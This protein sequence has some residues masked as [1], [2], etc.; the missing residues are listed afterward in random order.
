MQVAEGVNLD[1][2]A[3]IQWYML[4]ASERTFIQERLAALVGQSPESWPAD[5]VRRLATW[6]PLYL[7]NGN[8]DF[9]IFFRR[10]DSGRL[11]ILDI[12]RQEMLDR[13]FS[14]KPESMPV[15]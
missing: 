11:T 5:Q 15:P 4:P 2:G 8:E 9:R 14:K 3:T 6:E 7:L 13:Y 12:V 10:E 1:Y